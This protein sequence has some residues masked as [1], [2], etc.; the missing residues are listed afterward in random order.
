MGPSLTPSL[1][2]T[3]SPCLSDTLRD[4]KAGSPSLSLQP[5]LRKDLNEQLEDYR[6]DDAAAFSSY[7]V[8]TCDVR[9]HICF[10]KK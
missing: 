5:P 2:L 6:V 3:L 9:M 7:Y 8:P 1:T 4:P 10:D